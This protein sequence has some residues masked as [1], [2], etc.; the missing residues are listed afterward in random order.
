MVVFTATSNVSTTA[1][2]TTTKDHQLIHSEG[3]QAAFLGMSD[4]SCLSS[5]HLL[6]AED[7]WLSILGT[8]KLGWLV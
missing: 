8:P 4:G 7:D 3:Q 5:S 1:W 2:Q 6:K